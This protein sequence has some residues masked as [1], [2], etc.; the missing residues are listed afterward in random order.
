VFTGQVPV[1]ER[2]GALEKGDNLAATFEQARQRHP[3]AGPLDVSV[4]SV[5]FLTED[6]AE[7]Q[8]TLWL[9]G[10]GHSGMSRSGHAVRMGDAWKVARETWCGLVRMIGVECSPPE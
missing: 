7:V 6:E 8:F 4:D 1:E 5:R 10:F 2:C 9:G 3:G